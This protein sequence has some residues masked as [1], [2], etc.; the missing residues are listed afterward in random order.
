MLSLWLGQIVLGDTILTEFGAPLLQTER[1]ALD[2]LDLKCQMRVVGKPL[3]N[4]ESQLGVLLLH[5][6][7]LV[8]IGPGHN[9]MLEGW[10]IAQVDIRW[11]LGGHRSRPLESTP[12]VG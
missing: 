5:S 6:N 1:Y 8:C 11:E 3:C 10:G 9:M 7:D 2:G 4:M 12:R